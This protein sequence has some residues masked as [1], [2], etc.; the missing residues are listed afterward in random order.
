MKTKVTIEMTLE[1]SSKAGFEKILAERMPTT[2]EVAEYFATLI[3]AVLPVKFAPK[4]VNKQD[5][6]TITFDVV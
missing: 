4:G 1:C 2:K 6:I 3:G 5:E